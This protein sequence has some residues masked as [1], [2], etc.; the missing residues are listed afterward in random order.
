MSVLTIRSR[1]VANR[2]GMIRLFP[3]LAASIVCLCLIEAFRIGVDRGFRDT[4]GKGNWGRILLGV[5]TAI[6]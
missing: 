1:R 6:T 5:G 2:A 4:I 3:W